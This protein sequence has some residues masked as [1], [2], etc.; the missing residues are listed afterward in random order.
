M[1]LDFQITAHDTMVVQGLLVLRWVESRCILRDTEH[2]FRR[3]NPQHRCYLKGGYPTIRHSL[4]AVSAY[5]IGGHESK[6]EKKPSLKGASLF[7]VIV[8]YNLVK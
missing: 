1:H 4:A 3:F 2:L 8:E 6:M 5:E 7:G